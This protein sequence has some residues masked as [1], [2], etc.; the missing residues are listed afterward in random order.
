MEWLA[1]LVQL[2]LVRAGRLVEMEVRL[3]TSRRRCRDK[4]AS[5]G[6]R[7]RVRHPLETVDEARGAAGELQEK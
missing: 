6:G 3:Q 2:V 7:R 4:Q 1:K 5:G